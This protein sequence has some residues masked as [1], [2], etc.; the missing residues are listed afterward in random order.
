[1]P[2]RDSQ[3]PGTHL[4]GRQLGETDSTQLGGRLPEQPAQLR[5]RDAFTLMRLQVLLDP[6]AERQRRRTAAGHQPRQPV[7]K[8]LCASA[9][10]PNPP[11]CS[12]AEP[13]P[14]ARYRYAHNGSPSADVAFSLNT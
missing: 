9:L 4:L 3:P 12:L 7:L 2:L 5:D 14:A 1:M 13:R 10:L 8:R 11:T 6:L